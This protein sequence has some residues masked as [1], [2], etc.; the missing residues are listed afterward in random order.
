M[1]VYIFF[2]HLFRKNIG[3]DNYLKIIKKPRISGLFYGPPLAGGKY[4]GLLH[5]S[6]IVAIGAVHFVVGCNQF[7][8][9][10]NLDDVSVAVGAG[11]HFMIFNEEPTVGIVHL[12]P[13]RIAWWRPLVIGMT[14]QAGFVIT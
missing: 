7:I 2:V 4:P 5:R 13:V 9:M 3:R 10:R 11:P 14:L 12:R 8:G 6:L 1:E